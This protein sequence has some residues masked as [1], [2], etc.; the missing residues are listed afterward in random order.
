MLPT[1]SLSSPT[2]EVPSGRASTVLTLNNTLAMWLVLTSWAVGLLVLGAYQV[3]QIVATARFA[4]ERRQLEEAM[5]TVQ[6]ALWRAKDVNLLAD[7]VMAQLGRGVKHSTA[8]SRI[9]PN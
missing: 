7:S 9:S 2:N 4:E 6:V 8:Q 3:G 5:Q 1:M